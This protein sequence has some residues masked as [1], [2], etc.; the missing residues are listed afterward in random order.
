MPTA[1]YTLNK[2]PR[3]LFSTPAGTRR[4]IEKIRYSYALSC[5]TNFP[6]ESSRDLNWAAEFV[7]LS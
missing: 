2:Y 5:V 4:L 3:E 7:H 1:H 6:N